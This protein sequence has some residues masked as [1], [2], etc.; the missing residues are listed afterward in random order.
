M[1]CK[2]YSNMEQLIKDKKLA[3]LL[4]IVKTISGI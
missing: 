2:S 1:T 3:L 4:S